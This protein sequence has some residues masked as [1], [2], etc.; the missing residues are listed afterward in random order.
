MLACSGIAVK[1]IPAHHT[2]PPHFAAALDDARL[3]V[4]ESQRK[5]ATRRVEGRIDTFPIA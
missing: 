2:V 5:A 4:S 3:V 1:A